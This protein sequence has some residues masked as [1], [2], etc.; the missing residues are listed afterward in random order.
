[1]EQPSMSTEVSVRW[2]D[3]TPKKLVGSVLYFLV[4]TITRSMH[5]M[6]GVSVS[7]IC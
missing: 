3:T 4:I 1:M 2:K 5:G 7:C 6:F